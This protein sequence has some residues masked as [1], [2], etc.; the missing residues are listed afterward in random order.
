[1]KNNNIVKI[2][3]F[4]GI[5]LL[6]LVF[7]SPIQ[8]FYWRC[9]EFVQPSLVE[10]TKEVYREKSSEYL[11]NVLKRGNRSL[12]VAAAETLKERSDIYVVNEMIKIINANRDQELRGTSIY[13]LAEIGDERSIPIFMQFIKSG[14]EDVQYLNALDA[15]SMMHYE[16][17]YPEILKMAHD[18]YHTSWVVDMLA[19][20][21]EKP[22]TLP[23]LQEIAQNDPEWYIREKAKDAIARINLTKGVI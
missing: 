4:C 22:E 19:R 15:L 5:V 17:I 3:L 7:H 2:I 20:F 14:R 8:D 18:N 9:R 6:F 23:V 10:E 13:I 16:E 21:P 1:M 12:I 11:I